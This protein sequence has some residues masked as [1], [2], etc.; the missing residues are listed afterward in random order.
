M[1]EIENK[2]L[3]V[4]VLLSYDVEEFLVSLA[5]MSKEEK[6]FLMKMLTT[7]NPRHDSATKE[8]N[9]FGASLLVKRL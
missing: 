5:D 4:Y 8:L 9:A 1:G 7:P 6:D 3:G 2:A